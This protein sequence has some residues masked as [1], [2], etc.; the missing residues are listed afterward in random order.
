MIMDSASRIG[1]LPRLS[2]DL[3]FLFSLFLVLVVV[4]QR[5]CLDFEL[6]LGIAGENSFSTKGV[7]QMM[8]R[9]QEV[10]DFSSRLERLQERFA[11]VG[12]FNQSHS[13]IVFK[14]SRVSLRRWLYSLGLYGTVDS[15]RSVCRKAA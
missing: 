2:Q 14:G 7:S 9:T 15:K 3:R 10:D 1:R 13:A 4:L 5:C 11:H 8:N 12:V 6:E